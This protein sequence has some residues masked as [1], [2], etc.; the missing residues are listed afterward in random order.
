MPMMRLVAACLLLAVASGEAHG[1][2]DRALPAADAGQPAPPE[3]PPEDE[4][5]VEAEVPKE[6][7]RICEM[8]TETGSIIPRRVCRTVAQI[9]EDERT[10]RESL[11]IISRDRDTR[12]FVQMSRDQ[13]M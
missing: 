10:A 2:A 7:R 1:Q 9:E 11:E 12:S 8:R 13:G 3:E 4:I 6:R 5:V